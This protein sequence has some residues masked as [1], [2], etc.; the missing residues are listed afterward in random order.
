MEYRSSVLVS[1]SLFV[2]L[3]LIV[4]IHSIRT[5]SASNTQKTFSRFAFVVTLQQL[6]AA[7]T[8]MSAPLINNISVKITY[9]A[10]IGALVFMTA[11]SYYW[12]RYLGLL[13]SGDRRGSLFKLILSVSPLII[14]LITSLLSPITHWVFYID[15]NGIYQRGKLFF[16]QMACPYIY[17][18]MSIELGI[19]GRRTEDRARM[20]K[21]IRLFLLFMIPSI[22]GV[23]IQMFVVQG[24][25][26]SIGISMGLLL[27]Y[28]EIYIEDVNENKRLKSIETLNEKLYQVNE[29]QKKHIGEIAALNTQLQ[30]NQVRLER[31]AADQKTQLERISQLNKMLQ[32]RMSV[33]QS[34]SRVYFVSF[35]INLI[36]D[37]FTEIS[38]IDFVS[39]FV[40]K[41]GSASQALEIFCNRMVHPEFTEQLRNFAD[42]STLNDRMM[43]KEFITCDYLGN[44]A[45][46]CQL[47]F[48]EGDRDSVGN[49][50]TVFL[51]ARTI[52]DE[53]E[54]EFAQNRALDDARIAAEAASAAKTVFLN[55]I[56][57]DIRTPLN[58]ILGFSDLMAKEKNNPEIIGDYLMKIKTS[59]EYLLSIINNVLDMARIESGKVAVEYSFMDLITEEAK[60][61]S[62]LSVLVESSNRRFSIGNTIRH[63]YVMIDVAKHRQIM[64][65]LI[66]NAVKYTHEDGSIHLQVDELPCEKPGYG[67]FRMTVSDNGI[68]MTPEFLEHIFDSFARERNTTDSKVIG[69]GLGMSIVKRLVDILKG[70]IVVESEKGGGSRFIVTCDLELV[71]DPEAYIDIPDAD[72]AA[73]AHL[74]GKRILISEDNELNAEI[75]SAVLEDAGFLTERA[76]NGM[77]CIDM[78]TK[79]PKGYYDL[80]LMDIQMPL[81]NGYETSR[82]IREMGIQIPIVAMTANAFEEDKRKAIASGM[83][84]HLS[85]PIEIAKVIELLAKVL[86]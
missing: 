62:Y 67:T 83:N 4:L 73:T 77:V 81:L 12:Y 79:A 5:G 69:T 38:N 48:I 52:H 68:G 75:A 33:I 3:D 7:M 74:A 49:L 21:T 28:L 17:L 10:Y 56:S 27:M 65:N 76:E 18:I 29:E 72:A 16:L 41:N 71:D 44:V 78:L 86:K 8:Q 24:G 37:S 36:D 55:N 25:Y 42:F 32:E 31:S 19:S 51:A 84:G 53:K 66:S 15:D 30:D 26:S 85:K 9:L 11:S 80:I 60:T 20:R 14:I 35:F 57:H 45:G 64:M 43:N 58:A 40:G 50:K 23:F 82:R 13:I 46:W 6:F 1:L 47:Y 34:I 63:R 61:S 22:L 70:T 2:I 59:G 54:R 39:K